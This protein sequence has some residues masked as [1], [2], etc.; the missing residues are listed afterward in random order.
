MG[1]C[2]RAVVVLATLVVLPLVLLAAA[3][4]AGL[5]IDAQSW[6]DALA[7]QTSAVLGRP[8]ALRG[9]LQLTLGSEL[10]LRIGELRVLNPPG[11]EAQEFLAVGD[12]SVR[13]GLFDALRGQV[14][15]RG[16]EARDISL[17]L[18]RA[19]D[20]RGNWDLTPPREPAAPRAAIDLGRIQLTRLALRY[21][22]LRSTTRGAIDVDE[23]EGSVGPDQP[24][25]LTLRGQAQGQR[26]YLVRWK[27]GPLRQLQDDTQPWPFKLEFKVAGAR[28]HAGGEFD[29]GRGEARFHVDADANDLARVGRMLGATLPQAGA[30]ALSGSV[31]ASADAITLTN[32]QGT[33]GDS[34]F[35][36]QLALALGGVRQRLHGALNIATL[37]LRP[38]W[39]SEARTLGSPF[40]DSAPAWLNTALRDVVAWDLDL[41][42]SVGRW[43]GVPVAI[44]DAK[45]AL[46]ADSHGLRAPM[47]A[48]LAGA[49]VSGRFDLNTVAPTPA[50]ALQLAANELALGALARELSGADGLEGRLGRIDLRLAGRGDTLGALLREFDLSLTVAAAQTR[51]K[52][53]DGAKPIA[54]TFDT[55]KLSASHDQRLSGSARGSLMGE[56]AR[57]SIHGGT[58]PDML[59]QRAAPF[60]LELVLAQATLRLQG[61]LSR[62]EGI[63]ETALRFDFQ[64][65]HSGDLSR[66]L[67]LAP[68]SLLPVALRGQVRLTPDAWQLD[69][70]TLEIGRSQLRIE[71]RRTL[72][73]GRPLTTATLHSP[74]IDVAE[75]S[76]LRAGAAV[77]AGVP[78]KTG[79]RLDAPI[80]AAAVDLGDADLDLHLQQVRLG[81][82]D[83][84]DVGIVVRAREGRL[85]A[86]PVSGKLA[87]APFTALVEFDP[88]GEVP[89]AQLELSTTGIDLGALLRGLGVAE[90]IDGHADS[91][92]LELRGRGHSLRE[93][94]NNSVFEAKMAGGSLIVLGAAQRPVTEIRVREATIDAAAG[95]PIRVRLNGLLDRTDV[96]L[97]LS[98]GSLV[99]FAS[100][101]ARVP[102]S[103]LAQVAGTRLSLDGEV[104][105]P[106]GTAGQLTFEMGGERLDTLND[107]ARVEFPPWGPWSLR[108]PIRM[109]PSG[110]ELREL[111]LAVGQSRLGGTGK[112][113]ISSLRPRLDVQVAAPRIRLDDFPMPRRLTNDPPR[114]GNTDGLRVTASGLAGRTDRLLSAGFLRRLDA[115]IDIEAKEVLSGSDRLADGELHFK[116]TNGRLQLDPAVINLPGGSMRLSLSYDLK[117]SEVEFAA[118]AYVDHFDYGIIARRLGQGD[119]VRGLFS[120]N[121]DI[122][123]RAPSLNTIMNNANGRFDFAVWPTELRSGVFKLWSVNLVLTLLPLIDIGGASQVNCIVGRF[124][125]NNGDL[126]GDKIMI[127]TTA[128]RVRGEGHANLATEELAFIFRPRA[129][130]LALFRLQTPLHVTGT[131]E[132]QHFG[133]DRRDMLESVLLL[134][135]SPILL[136]V[137]RLT[138]GPLPRNGADLCTDPLRANG[139]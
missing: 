11:F 136:P 12:A 63:R 108:G 67:A 40:D 97:Q 95:E 2:R 42:L 91:L 75:L 115:S 4:W 46:H 71:A 96:R 131:L 49:A 76:T 60:D 124:D 50:F 88:S 100:D 9:M 38:L 101:A 111:Q 1:R 79:V 121:V 6:R 48:T 113:D 59:R 32:L 61:V 64:A 5:T 45:L 137:E 69:E 84:V 62:A 14:R 132:D 117:E 114:S 110:Y 28:L 25:L 73:A 8:V 47:S 54:I 29:A 98:T 109:T 123:G 58:V 77:N 10:L 33:W 133:H 70:T 20:G 139:R 130:G 118:A 127:D 17:W 53:A 19:T 106:L 129:K 81:R 125:L 94:I 35:A 83:L 22:D 43:L 34:E 116:L 24:L 105:L 86:S 51:Y 128:V 92:Q 107:L 93:W 57:L 85:L 138:L 135:A 104:T 90:D 119:D 89:F 72:A 66:W 13:I 74:L 56:R 30:A 41:D 16:I 26:P 7:Q 126:T 82:T 99:D 21:H 120:M 37:D 112:L 65:A 44:R 52:H 3:F 102:F 36:G 68:Q 31:V 27:S 23:L 122:A 55:L 80:L 134:I 15:L 103:L 18:E 78:A 87:G 39:E